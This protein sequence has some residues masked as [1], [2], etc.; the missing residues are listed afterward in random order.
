MID[1]ESFSTIKEELETF[2]KQRDR[3]VK[4]SRDVVKASKQVIFSM[5][6]GDTKGAK[7]YMENLVR[8]K[9]G[10]DDL[11]KDISRLQFGG[12]YKLVCQEYTEAIAYVRFIEEGKIPTP[13]DLKVGS[14]EY[15]LG[16]CDLSGELVR[17]AVADA[18]DK[19]LGEVE[20]T[21]KFLE[22]LY[23]QFLQLNPAGELR[24][25]IDMVRWNLNKVED[26]VYRAKTNVAPGEDS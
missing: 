5:N 8:G 14:E 2:D 16:L 4:A 13:Q 21:Q 6:R 10:M 19:R 22:E 3:V 17:K 20:K 1:E 18:T 15:L 9:E 26:I 12:S 7:E 23:A 11:V 25:K 24:K